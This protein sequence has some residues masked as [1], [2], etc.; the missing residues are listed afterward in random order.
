MTQHE[1]N[2][3][4]SEVERVASLVPGLDAVLCGGFLRGGLYLIQG[5]PGA[6]KTIL[7]N[8]IIYN[9]PAKEAAPSSS[10]CWGRATA[11]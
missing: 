2:A 4:Q 8:Q 5:P 7:A 9:Q 11:A 6:G 1:T 3:D 10:P